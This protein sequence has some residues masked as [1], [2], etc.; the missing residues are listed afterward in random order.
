MVSVTGSRVSSPP[1]L[2]F[3]GFAVHLPTGNAPVSV[4]TH[5]KRI[6]ASHPWF[7]IQIK[8]LRGYVLRDPALMRIIHCG[9]I[10]ASFCIWKYITVP[11]SKY[12]I[13]TSSIYF[14]VFLSIYSLPLHILINLL[15]HYYSFHLTCFHFHTVSLHIWFQ[16]CASLL[17]IQIDILWSFNILYIHRISTLSLP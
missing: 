13:S 8:V 9:L 14:S 10:T 12:L 6:Q 16:F 7:V 11:F 2:S 4:L 1:T 3:L 17:P 5:V 15:S